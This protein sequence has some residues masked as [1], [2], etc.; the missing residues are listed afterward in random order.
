MLLYSCVYVIHILFY[1]TIIIFVSNGLLFQSPFTLYLMSLYYCEQCKNAFLPENTTTDGAQLFCKKCHIALVNLGS[2]NGRISLRGHIES[3]DKIPSSDL[4][5]DFTLIKSKHYHVPKKDPVLIDCESKLSMNPLNTDALYT[6]SQWYFSQGLSHE[7]I[8]IAKQ[9]TKID[10]SFHKAHEF[11]SRHK[12]GRHQPDLNLPDDMNTLEDMAIN[13]FQT[14]Q[15]N[16]AELVLKKILT[17]NS[18]HAAARRYLA[19][20]YTDTGEVHEAIHQ[21]NR[22]ALQFP[23]DPRI[24]FNLAVACFNANDTSRA[25]SNL[26][27]AHKVCRDPVFI[28]EINQFL[29]YIN[30]QPSS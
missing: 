6:L 15:F 7:A 9:I 19:D 22:L 27:A 4:Y 12:T 28:E 21:L 10:P 13:L 29:N 2:E 11:L 16:K 24:L 30:D 3:Q 5:H 20:I 14:K 23:E 17:I 8:A 26:K 18:K 25:I 1:T